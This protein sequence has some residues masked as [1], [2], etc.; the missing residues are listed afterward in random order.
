[1]KTIKMPKWSQ[2]NIATLF[3][4]ILFTPIVAYFLIYVPRQ[5]NTFHKRNLRVLKDLSD[6]IQSKVE[7]AS[8]LMHN[9]ALDMLQQIEKNT[10]LRD[11]WLTTQS[12]Q[13]Y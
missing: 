8:T 2:F 3:L 4:I 6:Q 1:M 10:L 5:Q 13:D 12:I 11:L 7:N 9:A